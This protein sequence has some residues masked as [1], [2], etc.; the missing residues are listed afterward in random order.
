[1]A[2]H[3]RVSVW[4][5]TSDCHTC[6]R[7][8]FCYWKRSSRSHSAGSQWGRGHL[9]R[10]A[11]LDHDGE[12]QVHVKVHVVMEQPEA[13]NNTGSCSNTHANGITFLYSLK[14]K[15]VKQTRVTLKSKA[16]VC[17]RNS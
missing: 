6:P 15:L 13:C 9:V 2:L 4:Q 16:L 7:R 17:L 10:L 11:H 5:V 8:C 1:M 12:A 3:M 14:N